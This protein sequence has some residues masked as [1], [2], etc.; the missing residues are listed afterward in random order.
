[1]EPSQSKYR[2]Y[3]HAPKSIPIEIKILTLNKT[4]SNY[5][6]IIQNFILVRLNMVVENVLCTVPFHKDL[7]GAVPKLFAVGFFHYAKRRKRT[8][9]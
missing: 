4:I 2:N 9:L 3:N 8:S 6:V 5:T 1:M 7:Y